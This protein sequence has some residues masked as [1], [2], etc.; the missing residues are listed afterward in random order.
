[1]EK[2]LLQISNL[3]FCDEIFKNIEIEN[4]ILPNP[5]KNYPFMIIENFLSKKMSKDIVLSV[6]AQSDMQKAEVKVES[7]FGI[8]EGSLNEKYR[9]TNI[10]ELKEKFLK[11]YEKKF[12][13]YKP[14]IEK[15]FNVIL[16]NATDV[17]ALEYEKGFFYTKHADDSS[18]IVDKKGN[19]LG[20]VNIA[21][22]RKITTV[23][24]ASSYDEKAQDELHFTGGELLFNYLYD[25]SSQ[26]L[27]IKPKAGDMLVFPSNPYFSH[28]V[29]KVKFGYRLSLVQWHD[30]II[31]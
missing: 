11:L 24:F 16:T 25:E 8:V 23:L 9:K 5:Y 3:V 22:Q 30:A 7:E 31:L 20:F 21:P 26:P 15:F 12:S 14:Q 28:E 17:Q 18:E 2:K 6:K 1:M 13:R 27:K 4:K 10:Y 29:L 19:T